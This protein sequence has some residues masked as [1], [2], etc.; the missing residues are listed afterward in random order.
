MSQSFI[1]NAVVFIIVMV[2]FTLI[3]D[4]IIRYYNITP[5]ISKKINRR[6]LISTAVGL[7][8]IYLMYGREGPY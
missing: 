5:E 8:I 3:K 1:L 6:W 4:I 2:A 7:I